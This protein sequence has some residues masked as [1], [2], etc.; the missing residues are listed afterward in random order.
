VVTDS[1]GGVKARYDYLPY[2]EEVGSDHGTRSSVTGYGSTDKTRQKFTQK[3]RDSESGLDYFLAR[4]YSSA[5]GRFTS[6]DE[7]TNGP[8][9][10]YYFAD[11]A[12]ANP[13][14][15]ANLGNPQ[16]L[17]KYQ[18]GYNNPLRYVDP[19]GHDPLD[20]QERSRPRGIPGPAPLA[21]PLPKEAVEFIVNLVI[22]M[23]SALKSDAETVSRRAE[24]DPESRYAGEA[25]NRYFSKGDAQQGSS[26]VDNG[27]VAKQVE[28]SNGEKLDRP[29]PSQNKP[30]KIDKKS[31]KP[32]KE[33][34]VAGAQD[35]LNSISHRQ[36]TL[37]KRGQGEG[38]KSKKKSEQNLDKELKKIKSSKDLKE[39]Q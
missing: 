15:Y 13:L 22:D 4:Y 5:Q 9:D 23:A 2:G 12:S 8:D 16:S 17:N 24:L 26:H 36:D 7:F 35:Q 21:P 6:P 29:E 31:Q 11:D 30:Q 32:K 39:S 14:F 37:R 25:W 18:Y 20:P 33:S 3:E 34:S 28:R 10:L 38:L 1:T 19:D 27:S